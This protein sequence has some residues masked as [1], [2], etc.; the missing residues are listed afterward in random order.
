MLIANSKNRRKGF[1][2]HA[3]DHEVHHNISNSNQPDVLANP[4]GGDEGNGP[5]LPLE[6]PLQPDIHAPK[7]EGP[8]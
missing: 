4:H 3:N 5:F 7:H 1:L 6:I 8:S 2:N